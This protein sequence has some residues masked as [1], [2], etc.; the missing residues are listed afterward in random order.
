LERGFIGRRPEIQEGV[1][2]LKGFSEKY[3]LLIHG[4]AGI[5]KSCLAGKL[6]ERCPD[7]ALIVLHGELKASDLVRKLRDLFDRQGIASGLDVLKAENLELDE[8]IKAL[9]RPSGGL[10]EQPTILYC[11]DFEQNLIRRGDEHHLTPAARDLLIP[12]LT[13]LDW[14][15]GKTNLIITS[16]Y[17]FVLERDGVNLPKAKLQEISLMSVRKADVKKAG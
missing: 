1:R 6:I 3:G 10:H 13:A 12:L 4:P 14:A 16:R 11:D 17:P 15:E 2:V 9:F 5:G 7:K 8:K